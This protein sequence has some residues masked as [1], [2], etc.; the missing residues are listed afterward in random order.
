MLDDAVARFDID[1]K[2]VLV[3]GF[4]IGASLTWYLACRQPDL[5]AA[6]APVA[7]NFWRPHPAKCEGPV[8]LLH[9]HG[10]QDN[11]FPLE[12]RQLGPHAHGN[13]FD[14]LQ[15]WRLANGCKSAGPDTYETR[16][17]LWQRSWTACDSNHQVSLVLYAGGHED[18]P[19]EWADMARQWFE[20]R[21]EAKPKAN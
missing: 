9:T 10:W 15:L 18:P 3:S 2:R 20:A 11:V 21:L 6:F 1:R 12:G 4:S 19:K 17:T 14:G 13:T 8:D 7:G 5:G 16:A